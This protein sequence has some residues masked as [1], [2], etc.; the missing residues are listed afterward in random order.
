MGGA[1]AKDCLQIAKGDMKEAVK[2]LVPRNG[3]GSEALGLLLRRTVH[4][5]SPYC[6]TA[7]F[8][9]LAFPFRV[10]RG[11]GARVHAMRSECL[12]RGSCG[13]GPKLDLNRRM[14]K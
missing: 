10:V 3:L 14:Y 4:G 13:P 12:P 1:V 8:R 6:A 7:V 5:S 9:Y 2:L 11:N